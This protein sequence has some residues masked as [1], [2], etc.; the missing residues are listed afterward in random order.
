MPMS[1]TETSKFISYVLRHSPGAIGLSMDGHGKVSVKELLERMPAEFGLDFQG[2]CRIVDSD[3]K[4]R[5]SMDEGRTMIWANQ[6]HSISVD[7][8]MRVADPPQVLYH[9]TG[10]KFL[11]PILA[12][13]ILPKSRLYVHLSGDAETAKAVGSRHG[14]P[15]VLEVDAAAMRADGH[16][17]RLSAN[18]VWLV[19]SVPVRYVRIHSQR[20]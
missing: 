15:V 7:V 4:S 10:E 9:G 18:G 6:G 5:Y 1:D 13:G 2:L 17:F 3:P 11:A 14:R 19:G 20:G 12:E 16:T 8:E